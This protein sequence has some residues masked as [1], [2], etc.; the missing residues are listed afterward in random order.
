MTDLLRKDAKKHFEQNGELA[1]YG[2]P[3][4][5]ALAWYTGWNECLCPECAN[6]KVKTY[7]EHADDEDW[8]FCEEEL[9]QEYSLFQEGPPVLCDECNKTIYEGYEQC[10]VC[11]DWDDSPSMVWSE[12]K[13]GMLC[14]KCK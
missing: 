3:G 14:K 2:W 6:E 9:P 7:V 1:Y 11:E 13:G 5:Y 12:E 4:G 8:C 10:V